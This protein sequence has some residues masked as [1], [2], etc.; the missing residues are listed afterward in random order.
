MNKLIVTFLVLIT[1]SNF[2]SQEWKTGIINDPDGN[3][4]IRTGKG[5]NFG[6]IDLLYE[7]EI[8]QYAVS[9][10]ESWITIR[11]TKCNC[12]DPHG[13]YNQVIGFIHRS[14]IEELDKLDASVRKAL[15]SDIF[16]TE[17]DFYNQMINSSKQTSGENDTTKRKRI[18]FH[19]SQFNGSLNSFTNYLCELKDEEL[20]N[21]FL[22]L[23]EEEIGSADENPT[24]A[25]GQLFVCEPDWTFNQIVNHMTLM[26]NLEWG[27]LNAI[28]HMPEI[29]ANQHKMKY[30]ELRESIGMSEVDFSQY[31]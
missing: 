24:F 27:L 19:D 29:E 6:I 15:F 11:T 23:L 7:N 22:E 4:N 2:Y 25:L 14:R 13:F 28:Y 16:S 31:E 8:F 30:N 3:V 17:L 10:D 20:A 12:D 26:D 1:S 5:T 9:T 18:V 21:Q